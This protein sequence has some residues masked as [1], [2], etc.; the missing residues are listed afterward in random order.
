MRFQPAGGGTASEIWRFH[1]VFCQELK[2]LARGIEASIMGNWEIRDSFEEVVMLVHKGWKDN[3][4]RLVW[5]NKDV[6]RNYMGF[7][8]EDVRS[9]DEEVGLREVKCS[10]E[11]GMRIVAS[12]DPKR[13]GKKEEWNE[14]LE[15]NLIDGEDH[16]A[17]WQVD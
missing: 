13:R 4:I 15:E 3:G 6:M 7:G 2:M 17:T 1:Q 14:L 16:S 11:V 10:L 5:R 9:V 12:R 8:K